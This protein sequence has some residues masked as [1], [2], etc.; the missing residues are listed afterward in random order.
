[1]FALLVRRHGPL[2][3]GVCGRILHHTH[4]A[5]D[6][7]QATFLVLARKAGSLGWQASISATGY[8]R[9]HTG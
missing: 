2:V 6:V 1:A 7:F 3:L 5:E 8:T 4:D 9:W